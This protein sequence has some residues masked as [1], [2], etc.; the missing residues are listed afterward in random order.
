M[1][2]TQSLLILRGRFWVAA[3]V[4]GLI[5]G[6][7]AVVAFRLPLSYTATAAMLMD[8]KRVDQ[9]SGASLSTTLPPQVLQTYLATQIE[10]ILSNRTLT[11]VVKRLALEQDGKARNL[12]LAD[13]N[14]AGS[15]EAWLTDSLRK[16][17]QVKPSHDSHVIDVI[18]SGDSGKSAADLANAVAESALDT[19]LELKLRPARE[20]S[21]FFDERTLALRR[22]LETAQSNLSEYQRRTGVTATDDKFD[23]ESARLAELSSQLAA[24]QAVAIDSGSRQAEVQRGVDQLPEVLA[25]P[26]LQSLKADLVKGEAKLRE[27]GTQLGPNH[28]QYQQARSE[29][30]EL[31]AR[32]E[33][34]SARVVGSIGSSNRVNRDRELE[35]K[36]ALDVQKA[37]VLALRRQ[38]DEAAL[39]VREVELA[40]KDYEAAAQHRTQSSMES[41]ATAT[42]LSILDQATE[43]ARHSSPKRG[44][45]LMIAALFGGIAGLVCAFALEGWDR[46]VRSTADL[47]TLVQLPLLGVIRDSSTA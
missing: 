24:I 14:G 4:A 10:L 15:F 9:L 37:K 6:A 42:S 43:P 23:I 1:N 38:K 41:Q 18:A 8:V 45:I 33:T 12:W 35:I 34:E 46:R 17:L 3:M 16:R 21:A 44:L 13:T 19:D 11:K 31:R 5:L 32:L 40:Q 39:L 30:E 22:Q 27:L 29:V 26:L 36:R 47:G 28:P 2:F 20:S 25:S 7:A